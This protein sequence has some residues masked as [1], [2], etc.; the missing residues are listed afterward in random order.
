MKFFK[1]LFIVA[2][3]FAAVLL[4]IGVFVPEIDEEIN[5]TIE[6]PIVTVYA[7]LMNTDDLTEWVEG[8]EK[9]ERTGG[10]LAMPG[11]TFDLYFKSTETEVKY[12][13]EIIELVPLKSMKYKLYND[14]ME[15]EVSTHF[16]INGL[17]TDME[18]FVQAKGKG[19]L[20]RSFLPLMKSVVMDEIRENFMAFKRLQEQ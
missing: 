9:I 2:L 14:M 11:S 5:L 8:L 13:L 7:G 17:S 6:A 12:E 3:L 10:I 1:A 15:I 19:L 18:I 16:E 4:M 20:V